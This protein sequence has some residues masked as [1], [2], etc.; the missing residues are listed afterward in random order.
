M[1]L[2]IIV[3]LCAFRRRGYSY[4]RR[5]DN[6]F[7]DGHFSWRT[8]NRRLTKICDIAK[9]FKCTVNPFYRIFIPTG[10]TRN[11]TFYISFIIFINFYIYSK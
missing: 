2:N 3:K 8:F 4:L 1:N 7:L 9:S 10:Y 5:G 6:L 11:R